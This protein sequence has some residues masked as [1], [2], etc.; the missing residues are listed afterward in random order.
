MLI[1]FGLADAVF[2]DFGREEV[3]QWWTDNC[4]YLVD[5]GTAGIWDDM[6]EPASF[7]G[8]IPIILSLVME[9]TFLPIRNCIMFTDIIWQRPLTMD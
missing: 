1:R 9:N 5:T 3:Q 6:N 4:K 8:E 2:P 7:E